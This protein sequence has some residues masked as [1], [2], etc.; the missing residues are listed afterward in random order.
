MNTMYKVYDVIML[1]LEKLWFERLRKKTVSQAMGRV[2]EIGAGTGINIKYYNIDAIT[3]L[4]LI[5][6]ETEFIQLNRDKKKPPKVS[7]H[8]G[9]VMR[10]PFED[11]FFDTVVFTL[12]FCS[13]E[14]PETGLSEIKRVLK[15]DGEIFFIEHVISCSSHI[16]KVQTLLTH[17]WKKI[18][19]NCHL[20][21]PTL[22]YIKEAGFT[23]TSLEKKAVCAVVAGSGRKS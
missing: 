21:R 12:L 10:L 20:D 13:V 1:P 3:S 17:G 16:A 2:L 4:D 18:A 11:N 14:D 6:I 22:E 8:K 19:G 5:D 7:I 23:I 9:D 15:D